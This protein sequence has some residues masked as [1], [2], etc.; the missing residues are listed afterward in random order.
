MAPSIDEVIGRIDKDELVRLVLDICNIDSG[1]PI[2]APVARYVGNWLRAQGFKVR[3]VGLLADRFNVL[4]R[5]PGTG[6]GYS[7]ILNS[8]MDTAVR[9]TDTWSRRD[10]DDDVHHK[11]WL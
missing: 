3:N 8:H 5:L 11:A 7:L 9:S 1:G 10:P 2:E 4:A 6:G